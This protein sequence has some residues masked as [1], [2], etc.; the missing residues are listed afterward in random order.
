[1]APS[2]SLAQDTGFS[3][4]Q[5]GFKSPWGHSFSQVSRSWGGRFFVTTGEVLIRSFLNLRGRKWVRFEAWDVA[6]NGAFTQPV[7]LSPDGN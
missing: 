5:Q 4:L 1:M 2:S 6:A 7:W 3:S